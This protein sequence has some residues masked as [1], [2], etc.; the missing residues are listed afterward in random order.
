VSEICQNSSALLVSLTGIT[1]RFG[2]FAANDD[3]S[4]TIRRGEAHALL[5]ENGAGKSTLVKILFGL[6]QPDQGTIRWQDQLV[7]IPSPEAARKLGIAMVFQHFSLFDSL[8]VLE[9][10]ALGLPGTTANAALADRAT[11]LAARYGLSR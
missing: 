10:I 4:L 7:K 2:A 1:K 8:S 6:L 9:N 3:V 11:A 5:G